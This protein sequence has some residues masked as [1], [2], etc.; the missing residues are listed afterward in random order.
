MPKFLALID[1][2]PTEPTADAMDQ[3]TDATR[4]WYREQQRNNKI[5]AAYIYPG[6][7]GCAIVNADSTAEVQDLFE[8]NPATPFLQYTVR[9]LIDFDQAMDRGLCSG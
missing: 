9:P 1:L 4:S 3:A 7:G 6:G 2:G 8:K 5:E